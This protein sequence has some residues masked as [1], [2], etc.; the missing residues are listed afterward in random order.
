MFQLNKTIFFEYWHRKSLAKRL[1]SSDIVYVTTLCKIKKDSSF[2][3]KIKNYFTGLNCHGIKKPFLVKYL[4]RV[5]SVKKHKT[6]LM[7]QY[8]LLN[9]I[10]FLQILKL[11]EERFSTFYETN[12][13][14]S[15]DEMFFFVKERVFN[16]CVSRW[17]GCFSRKTFTHSRLVFSF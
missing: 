14:Q 6:R 17:S 9:T 3:L 10:F 11:A 4:S 7:F 16:H 1:G 12:C 5:W 15:L 2:R 13:S 8:Y